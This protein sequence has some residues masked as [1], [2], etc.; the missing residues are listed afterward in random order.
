MLL[1]LG[2][3]LIDFVRVL[4][5]GVRELLLPLILI[6]DQVEVLRLDGEDLI[7]RV[8]ARLKVVTCRSAAGYTARAR[9]PR[10][11]VDRDSE[12]TGNGVRVALEDG[13]WVLVRA[14]S[15]KPEMVVVVESM[16]SADDMRALFRDEV[17]PR[18]A[19]YPA[20][21]AYNQEI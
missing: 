11:P 15:N 14:S 6:V 5:A 10:I 4:L 21:G 13:S 2:L 9:R 3:G 18:L 19:K 12:R 20:V 16:S 8:D 7:R 1:I 17:K